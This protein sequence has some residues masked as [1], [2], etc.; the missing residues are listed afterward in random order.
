MDDIPVMVQSMCQG[1]MESYIYKYIQLL[2][3][4]GV[5]KDDVDISTI[6]DTWKSIQP[7]QLK[8]PYVYSRGSKKGKICGCKAVFG[9]YCASHKGELLSSSKPNPIILQDEVFM[10][11]PLKVD[12]RTEE[13][14]S[15]SSYDDSE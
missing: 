4:Q 14:L 7:S 1:V 3:K 10:Y 11:V 8:C 5:F 15:R 9:G 6:M 2:Y 13:V 12:E